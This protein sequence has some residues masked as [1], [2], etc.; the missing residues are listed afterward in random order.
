MIE[1]YAGIGSRNITDK[2]EEIIIKIANKLS[3]RFLLYSGNATGADIAFQ[4][5]SNGN[6]VVMLPEEGF[7]KK[8]FDYTDPKLALGYYSVGNTAAGLESLYEHHE[9]PSSLKSYGKKLMCRNHHQ[10]YGYGELD[11]VS[12]VVCCSK[13]IG[14]IVEGGT[15]QAVRIAHSL[16]IPVVN[17]RVE[18]WQQKLRNICLE[19]TKDD[20][21]SR[22]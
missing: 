21:R 7:N 11:I 13:P 10:I 5:G 1:A 15:R 17:I 20:Y 9:N 6:C 2:E 12:F 16:D 22:D 3:K 8:H 14:N 18:G 19:L 4:R